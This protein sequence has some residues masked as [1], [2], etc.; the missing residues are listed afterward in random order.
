VNGI[1]YSFAAEPTLTLVNA[2]REEL[3]FTGVKKGCDDGDCGACS[4]LYNGQVIP[5]CTTLAIEAQGGKIITIEGI[6]QGGQLHPVQQAF[7]DC[8]AIQCGFC[9][10]GMVLATIALLRENPEPTEDEIRSYLRG[11]LCRC[12]GYIKIIEAVNQ[13]GEMLRKEEK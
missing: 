6:G 4:V 8:F 11:N 12:T 2:L 5:S 1:D 10:P 3:R 7:V 9:T 13:A